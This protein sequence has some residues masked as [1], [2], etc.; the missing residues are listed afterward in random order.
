MWSLGSAAGRAIG[1]GERAHR[2]DGSA[3]GGREIDGP[4]QPI[5]A[6]VAVSLQGV[7]VQ[8]RGDECA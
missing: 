1:A 3:Q 6:S 2:S 5:W 8:V 7:A 4:R